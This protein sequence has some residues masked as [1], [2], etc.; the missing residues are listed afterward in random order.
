MP[1]Y[2]V[3][4]LAM[5]VDERVLPWSQYIHHGKLMGTYTVASLAVW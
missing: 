4:Q 1:Y 5:R 2:D 3:H